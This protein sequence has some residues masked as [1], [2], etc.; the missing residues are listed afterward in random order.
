M[1]CERFMLLKCSLFWKFPAKGGIVSGLFANQLTA[2]W[3]FFAIL[4]VK[5]LKSKSLPS[6]RPTNFVMVVVVSSDL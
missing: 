5:D 1:T 4:S 6:F 2:S 3:Y